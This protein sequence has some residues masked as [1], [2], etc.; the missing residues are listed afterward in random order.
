[1]VTFLAYLVFDYTCYLTMKSLDG[2]LLRVPPWYS[3]SLWFREP[4]GLKWFIVSQAGFLRFIPIF[5]AVFVAGLLQF[6]VLQADVTFGIGL[7]IVGLQWV[8]T[9]AGG[10]VM[11]L[12]FGVALS[13]IGATLQGEPG[14]FAP[15]QA[16]QQAAPELPNAQQ[17]TKAAQPK[18]T[19]EDMKAAVAVEQKHAQERSSSG[20]AS[21]E[22]LQTVQQKAKDVVKTSQE[23]VAQASEKLKAYADPYLGELQEAMAPVTKHLPQPV[24]DF[25]DKNGWWWVLGG[26]ALVVLLWVRSLVRKL[27]G[28]GH[29]PKKKKRKKQKGF[30]V[31]LREDLKWLGEGFSAAGPQQ[32]L[33]KG[34][35][36]RLRLVV[37]SMGNK[38][39]GELSEEMADR[40]LDEIMPGLAEVTSYDSPGVRVWPAYLSSDGFALAVEGNLVFPEPKGMKSHWIVMAGEVRIGRLLIHVGLALH[41]EKANNLRFVK[42]KGERWLNSL[43]VAKV[44]E[45]AAAW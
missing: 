18:A 43:A 29:K 38:S 20:K 27:T 9:L 33:V 15:E 34:L 25:L 11:S 45:P 5:L 22:S 24:Q 19:A 1:V 14:K 44:K 40:V 13:A 36:A 23:Q 16:R 4:I 41:A 32:L 7:A 37:L 12:L 6:I 8:A 3:Y 39:G 28:T 17:K 10:Y 30:P 2:E 26:G 35:P 42:V 21:G 31:R